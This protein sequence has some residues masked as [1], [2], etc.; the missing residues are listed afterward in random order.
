MKLK[1]T[2]PLISG[3][4]IYLFIGLIYA[5]SIFVAP[6]EAEFG[7]TRT[8]TSATFTISM[9]CFVLG[10]IFSG[11]LTKRKSA[12]FT[13]WVAAV[14][15][16]IGFI[17]ASRVESIIQLYIAY[18]LFCGFGVGMAYNADISTVVRWFPEKVGFISGALLMCFG[19]GGL[20]L[21][22]AASALIGY[23]GWRT[24]FIILGIAFAIALFI[25]SIFI[26]S[27]GKDVVLPEKK[28]TIRKGIEQGLSLTADKMIRRPAFWF[29]LFWATI[30]SGAGLAI[31]GHAAVVAQ[32]IGAAVS[33]A[34][35]ITGMI[36]VCNGLGRVFFGMVFDIKGRKV[37]VTL[38]NCTMVFAFILLI[39]ALQLSSIPL[40]IAGSILLGLA[41]GSQP[42]INSTFV[43]SFYGAEHYALNLSIMNTN[44][45]P[46]AFLGPLLAGAIKT[47]TGSYLM[48][49]IIMLALCVVAYGF[50]LAIKKP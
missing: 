24:T 16:L 11:F 1:R 48:V 44:L 34:T 2:A 22:S 45:I 29:Q 17:S 36:S 47:A 6:L 14:L 20:F 26:V 50:Q 28:T 21:G 12:R 32:D 3:L 46:S 39:L 35:V 10:G 23:T 5:W 41:F 8:Q 13:L 19:F 4:I 31:I 49:F 42:S 38:A 15:L 18:G 25:C 30:L 37:C 43:N 7:W 9:T 40:L 27:P 33:L